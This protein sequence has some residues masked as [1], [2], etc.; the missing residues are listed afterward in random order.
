MNDRVPNR[1][2]FYTLLKNHTWTPCAEFRLGD[3]GEVVL[4]ILDAQ[5]EG[6]LAQEYYDLGAPD[7]R[8]RRLVDRSDPKKFMRTVA[9]MRPS[10]YFRWVDESE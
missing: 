4:E 5:F 1:L 8:E 7:D 9:N 6:G 2:V 3:S 10:T